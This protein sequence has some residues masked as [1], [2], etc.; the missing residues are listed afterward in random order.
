[1]SDKE[2]AQLSEFLKELNKLEEDETDIKIDPKKEQKWQESKD[3]LFWTIREHFKKHPTWDLEE[4]LYREKIRSQVSKDTAEVL[5]K[6]FGLEFNIDI[7]GDD[8]SLKDSKIEFILINR[9][10][11]KNFSIKWEMPE[12]ILLTK[13]AYTSF[14][15]IFWKK[16]KAKEEEEERKWEEQ[17]NKLWFIP[18]MFARL[19]HW[20]WKQI[21]KFLLK[22]VVSFAKRLFRWNY[23]MFWKSWY[24]ETANKRYAGFLEDIDVNWEER[25]Y[26]S[27]VAYLQQRKSKFPIKMHHLLWWQKRGWQ[28]KNHICINHGYIKESQPSSWFSSIPTLV[29]TRV[30]WDPIGK[31]WL[32]PYQNF[33]KK[34]DLFSKNIFRNY[35]WV[36]CKAFIWYKKLDNFSFIFTI[37]S[38]FFWERN[39]LMGTLDWFIFFYLNEFVDLMH[40]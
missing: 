6:N 12:K 11:S 35:F 40:I 18:R 29:K 38:F 31:L 13:F 28:Y 27:R 20:L 14:W 23:T 3:Q 34:L 16:W 5:K 30:W 36:S 21:K 9:F 32:W 4:T 19:K 25:F 10:I 17:V 2:K 1:M 15:Q 24:A 39:T 37:F 22:L 8:E 33:F 7:H 26:K